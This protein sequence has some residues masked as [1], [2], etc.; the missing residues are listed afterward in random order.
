LG[1]PKAQGL[2]PAELGHLPAHTRRPHRRPTCHLLSDHSGQDRRRPRRRRQLQ[3]RPLPR[4]QLRHQLQ[5][6]RRR[7]RLPRVQLPPQRRPR[8]LPRVQLPPQRRPRR[9]P[10]VQLPPQR[11]PRRLPRVQLQHPDTANYMETSPPEINATPTSLMTKKSELSK[12]KKR[13]RRKSIDSDFTNYHSL[14]S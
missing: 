10:R 12:K 8:R 4:P 2:P 1:P 3:L 7:Q 11:R 5:P 13:K 14:V 9:L 6:K